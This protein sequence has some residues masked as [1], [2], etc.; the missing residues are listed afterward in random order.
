MLNLFSDRAGMPPGNEHV[1][2]LYPFWGKNPE[3]DRDPS[4]GRFDRYMATGIGW[5]QMTSLA[6]ADAAVL[7]F[8]WHYVISNSHTRDYADQFIAQA[9][10]A[11]KPTLVFWGDDSD[12][13][14][15]LQSTWVFR[16]S[17]YRSHQRH[18]EFAMPAWSEDFVAR[19]LGGQLPVR[20][21]RV[22]P[23]VGFCGYAPSLTTSS[24]LRYLLHRG[25]HFLTTLRQ[26][27]ADASIRMAA[28][29]ML[30]AS[31][32]VDTNFVIRNNFL[33]GASRAD[34]TLDWTRLQSARHE[35]VQNLAESDYILCARGAGNF[36]Y[37]LYETLCCGRI[38]VFVDTDCVLPYHNH[39]DWKSFCVWVDEKELQQIGAKVADFHKALSVDEFVALQY[40]CR[41]LWEDYLSPE[42]FFQNFGL[43]FTSVLEVAA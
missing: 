43:H 8:D 32:H 42:G 39:I 21:K 5:F 17:L 24:R 37:R 27:R 29:H 20:V 3:D 2:I 31:S 6:E 16:T 4:S 12:R 23:T 7:P 36:S 30:H 28:L 15:G 25:K 14:I 9:A 26:R 19:Y 41:K 1:V 18:N 33:G 35:F 10:H 11:G 22:R 13:A 40:R 38:P 34:G